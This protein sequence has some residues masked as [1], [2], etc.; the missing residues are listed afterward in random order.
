LIHLLPES[1]LMSPSGKFLVIPVFIPHRG[2][3]HQCLFCN[4]NSITGQ[5]AGDVLTAVE[6][7][8]TTWLARSRYRTQVQVAFYGGSFTCL[9][10]EQQEK[11]L[12]VVQ[13]FLRR[14]DVQCIR[15]STRPDCLDFALC[16]FLQGMGVGIVELGVQSLDDDVLHRSRRG[17]TSADCRRAVGLLQETGIEVG[18]QLMPGLP[19]ESGPSFFRGVREVIDL[20]PAF[21]RLYPVLVV[22]HSGLAEIY[23]NGDYRPLTMNRAVALTCRAREMF[24]QA[25]IRVVRIGLQPSAS[26]ER[27]L[28][29]GPY[30]PAFGELVVARSWFRKIRAL[31]ARCPAGSRLTVQ[32]SERDLS[33]FLGPKRMNIKRLGQL[34]LANRLHVET[35][36]EMQRGTLTYVVG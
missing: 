9:P 18:I 35:D 25:G 13:P 23:R 28:L 3:P 6:K 31:L 32:I 17:H 33:A 1:L 12:R 14:G 7:T 8:I 2:C 24:L 19:G 21:V 34:A 16:T 26:L 36:K 15:V 27:D 4:Q 5:T 20:A 10:E 22:D 29:A 30:H 11:M